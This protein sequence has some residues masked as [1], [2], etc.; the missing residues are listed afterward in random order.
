MDSG[1]LKNDFLILSLTI[2]IASLL[3]GSIRGYFGILHILRDIRIIK[4][5]KEI[6]KDLPSITEEQAMPVQGKVNY[7]RFEF[8][9]H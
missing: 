2:S 5:E 9:P 6:A 1:I 8:L 3:Y 4:Q 7:I